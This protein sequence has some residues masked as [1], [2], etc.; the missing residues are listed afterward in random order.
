MCVDNRTGPRAGVLKKGTLFVTV[1]GHVWIVRF[2]SRFGCAGIAAR[3]LPCRMTNAYAI[4][5]SH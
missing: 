3:F 2:L 5:S 4:H 1:D